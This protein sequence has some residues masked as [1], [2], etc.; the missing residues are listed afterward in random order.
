MA[1]L[2]VVG[3][4]VGTYFMLRSNSKEKTANEN[5]GLGGDP[6]LCNQTGIEANDAA[7]SAKKAATWS[8]IAG[9]ALITGGVVLIVVDVLTESKQATGRL[10]LHPF[11]GSNAGSLT[12][13]GTF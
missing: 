8:Y 11:V 4:G 13:T 10:Q 3:V 1:S 9:G 6:N 7:L 5:C 2:G 12:L